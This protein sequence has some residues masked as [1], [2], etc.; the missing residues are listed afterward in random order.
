MGDS[1]Q[2]SY[3]LNFLNTHLVIKNSA[4]IFYKL[5]KCLQNFNRLIY[6]LYFPELTT[7]LRKSI[8]L[9]LLIHICPIFG[10]KHVQ[11]PQ[12]ARYGPNT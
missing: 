4:L 3:V 7:A 9:L 11:C 5:S 8:Y 10:L 6:K 12:K 1:L 2:R